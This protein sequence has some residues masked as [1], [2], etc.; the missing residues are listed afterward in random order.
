MNSTACRT[1]L[2]AAALVLVLLAEPVSGQEPVPALNGVYAINRA[3]V[4]VEPGRELPEATVVVREGVVTEVGAGVAPP[5]EAMVLDGEGLTVCAGF[6]V[7]GPDLE[8]D[9]EKAPDPVPG[10][11]SEQGLTPTVEAA[12]LLPH[13]KLDAAAWRS[14]GVTALVLAPEGGAVAGHAVLLATGSGKLHERQL[15][16]RAALALTFRRSRRGYPR[17]LM[18]VMASL[19]QLFFD[20]AWSRQVQA[21]YRRDPLGMR[22]PADTPGLDALAPV[23]RGDEPVMVDLHRDGD[24]RRALDLA[25]QFNLTAWLRGGDPLVKPVQRLADT[26]AAA[27]VELD[28]GEVAFPSNKELWKGPEGGAPDT[29]EAPETRESSG[30]QDPYLALR[31]EERHA[32]ERERLERLHTAGKRLAQAE[33]PFCFAAGG[34]KHLLR[35]LRAQV[36]WGLSPEA[37]LAALTTTPAEL[38]GR[39]RGH[40]RV[41]PGAAADLV[42][43]RGDP[44]EDGRI[45]HVFITGMRYDVEE[46]EADKEEEEER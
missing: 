39:G 30:K 14:V 19:R 37:A 43:F 42:V 36:R 16:R 9:P 8:V 10:P 11:R 32:E 46:G 24:A 21:R 17:S 13:V 1:S 4:L 38:L 7:A 40:G 33:V 3:R 12:R 44:F 27:M 22:P 6:L 2:R 18:G 35:R 41:I 25:R 26:G 34:P 45:R 15:H 29:R 23:L 31:R 20:A 28:P 5:P